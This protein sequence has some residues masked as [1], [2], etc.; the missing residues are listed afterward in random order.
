MSGLTFDWVSKHLYWTD[1]RKKTVEVS[2]ADGGNRRVLVMTGKG[3][4]RGIYADPINGYLFWTDQGQKHI[5]RSRLDGSE[6]TVIVTQGVD[7]PNQI[8]VYKE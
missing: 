8:V 6:Q 7:L 4:P 2:D 3:A 1:S 5:A